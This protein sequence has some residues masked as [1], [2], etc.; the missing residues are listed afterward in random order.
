MLQVTSKKDQQQYW[1]NR[2]VTYRYISVTEFASRFKAFHVGLQLENELSIP[3]E[4]TKS[5]KAALVF[6]KY[7]IPKLQILKAS[8]DRE[9]L[10]IKRTAPF[11][12]FKTVQIIFLAVI[13]ST[14]FLRTSH[15]VSFP[16]GELYIG[17]MIF[18]MIVNMF[19]G[20][21]E[22][23]ITIM[24]LPVFYKHRDLLFY[25]SWAFTIPNFLL[26]LPMSLVE[27]IVWTLVT[28]FSIGYT[29]DG[30][31]CVIFIHT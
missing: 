8:I 25:P 7:T 27:S 6:K 20:F 29:P 4:K 1:A 19:N 11:Y 18:A 21:P 15:H 3:Y 17:A 9:K 10:L 31:R 5:H 2:D 23:S 30:S 28:Y 12:I 14:V 24:R 22:V 26:R 13:A 16:D